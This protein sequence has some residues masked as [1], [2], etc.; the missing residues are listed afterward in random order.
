MSGLWRVPLKPKIANENY[1]TILLNQTDPGK[2]INSFYEI[3]ITEQV[4]QYLHACDGSTTKEIRLKAIGRDN[5]T[6]W[7]GLTIKDDNKYYPK[8]EETTK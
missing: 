8:L 5:Y 6:T 1:D 2:P 3:P 4:I 7:P